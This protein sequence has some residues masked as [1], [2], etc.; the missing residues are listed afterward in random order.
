MKSSGLARAALREVLA[1][2]RV[3]VPAA[4]PRTATGKFLKAALREQLR[5]FR[6]PQAEKAPC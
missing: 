3:R 5:D 2:G 4:D 1:A 6:L